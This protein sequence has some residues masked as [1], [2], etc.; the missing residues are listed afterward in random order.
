[1][2]IP[3]SCAGFCAA[4]VVSGP[5][6]QVFRLEPD[7]YA[8]YLCWFDVP[9]HPLWQQGDRS[10][11]LYLPHETALNK[12]TLSSRLSRLEEAGYVEVT[13]TCR[14][15]GPQTLLCLTAADRKAFEQCRRRLRETFVTNW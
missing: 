14:G 7:V 10:D 6:V 4:R 8:L 15:K 2:E 5:L 12:G 11:F 3:A 9:G 1:M 13:K